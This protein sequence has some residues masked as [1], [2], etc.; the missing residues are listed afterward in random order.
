MEI[1]L[2][3]LIQNYK[4]ISGKVISFVFQLFKKGK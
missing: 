1:I 3:K 4:I 2:L